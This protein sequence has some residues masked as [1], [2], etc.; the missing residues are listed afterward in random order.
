MAL[1]TPAYPGATFDGNEQSVANDPGAEDPT[2]AE[3]LDH[4]KLATEL[5]AI[6]DD[7]RAAFASESAASLLA[8]LQA[9]RASITAQ[10]THATQHKHGGSDEVAQ[11][12]P[13][14][15]AIPKAGGGGTLS[16][17]WLLQATE[18]ARGAL[19]IATQAETDLGT[20]DV[21]AVTPLKLSNRLAPSRGLYGDG[22]D[23]DVVLGSDATLTRDTFYNSLDLNGWD[24][25][26]GGFKLYCC[27]QLT[28]PVGSR[29]HSDGAPGVDGDGGG[30]GGAAGTIGTLESGAAGG[31]AAAVGGSTIDSLG[32]DGGGGGAGLTGP[33]A[34]GTSTEPAASDGGFR[35]RNAAQFGCVFSTQTPGGHA[36]TFVTGGAG[37]GGGGNDGVNDGGGA[38]AGGGFV[39]VASH[40]LD[41]VGSIGAKGGDGADGETG[42]NAG[43]GGGGGGGIAVVM[44]DH[45]T[46]AGTIGAAA[47]G[48]GSGAGTGSDGSAGTA[49]LVLDFRN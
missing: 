8:A 12:A 9:L 49:G 31:A 34:G 42:S 43:G 27:E 32:G 28:V 41:L 7:L 40:L 35:H 15:N 11:S 10:A 19:E 6:E 26:T 36:V 23:G 29:I 24:L 44:T 47:G 48:A 1:P 13:G 33:G 30:A 20:D 16:T 2:I 14:A 46:G 18:L 17:G 3:G 5:V 39:L 21:R 4:N 38:G 37:G 25:D 45:P 22:S